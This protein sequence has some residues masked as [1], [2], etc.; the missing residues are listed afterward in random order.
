MTLPAEDHSNEYEERSEE[1]GDS[2]S[3]SAPA[4]SESK[5]NIMGEV[6]ESQPTDKIT[7]DVEEYDP[8][9]EAMIQKASERPT[10]YSRVR[11][12]SEPG[13][14]FGI[15]KAIGSSTLLKSDL[16]LSILALTLLNAL[17]FIHYARTE[18]IVYDLK[19]ANVII[20]EDL[21]RDY[22]FIE[23]IAD[24]VNLHGDFKSQTN[25]QFSASLGRLRAK[26]GKFGL[27]AAGLFFQDEFLQ[28]NGGLY[29]ARKAESTPDTPDPSNP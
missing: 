20:R 5:E 1:N 19:T 7:G 26:L 2:A 14:L 8:K 6:A 25:P 3:V 4:A 23:P 10:V 27:E 24:F 17:I 12:H 29:W 21:G 11:V 15:M 16:F 18:Q 9:V 22:D 13:A 28:K